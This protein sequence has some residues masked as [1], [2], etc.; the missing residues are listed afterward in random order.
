[1][2]QKRFSAISLWLLLCLVSLPAFA[3]TRYVKP[4][5]SGLGDGSSWANASGDLQAMINASNS[6]D[7]IWVSAG[8]YIPNRRADAINVITVNDRRNAFVLK[9]G[10]K[11]YGGFT[12]VITETLLSQRNYTANVTILSGDI[13]GT[14]CYHVV[15]AAGAASNGLLD[16]FTVSNGY[17]DINSGNITVNGSVIV[18][19][20]GAGIYIT[21]SSP[22]IQNCIITSNSAFNGISVGGAG[23]LCG[24]TASPV[25]TNCTISNNNTVNGTGSNM[26]GAGMY[27]ASATATVSNC[28]FNNNIAAGE[29][30]GLY[31][32]TTVTSGITN[33]NFTGNSSAV[34]GGGLCNYSTIAINITGCDFTSNSSPYGAGL[35]N[36]TASPVISNCNFLSNTASSGGG[37]MRNYATASPTVN[38][39]VFSGNTG[40]TY[41]GGM[42]NSSTSAP[43]VTNCLFS[44]NTATNGGG[45]ANDITSNAVIVNSTIAANKAI[46]AGGGVYNSFSIPDLKN[47]I[48]YGNTAASGYS[49]NGTSS[50]ITYSNIEGGYFGTGNI[51]INPAFSSPQLASSAP[52]TLGDYHLQDCSPAFNLG[53]NA[54]VPSNITT[55][56]Q[57]N[58]RIAYSTVDMGPYEVQSSFIFTLIPTAGILYVDKTKAG[59]GSSWANAVTE[60]A[61]A[62]KAAKYNSTITQIWVAKGTYNPLYDAA[63]LG[64]SP[65]NNRDQSFVLVNNVKVYGSFSGGETTLNGRDF[66]TNETILSGDIGIANDNADNAYHVLI[67]AGDIGNAVLDGFSVVKGE[68]G[69]NSQITVNSLLITRNA[70]GG[71]INYSSS[72]SITNCTISGNSSYSAGGMYNYNSS[73]S[74]VNCTISGNSAASAGGGMLNSFS[75]LALTNCTVSSNSSVSHGGGIYNLSLSTSITNCTISGNNS[76]NGNGGGMYN[77]SS[78]PVITNCA[79][80]GNKSLS[81]GGG[82]L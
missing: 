77:F 4:V 67:S 13:T 17:A 12:G 49:L 3:V 52:T 2:M 81:D 16:G 56:L 30:G 62:L 10:V 33:C 7:E 40:G 78:S 75:S 58:P 8:T 35:Y 19:S 70:G 18:A 39:C 44:G 20:R 26:S 48:V 74:I 63:T 38:N 53:N 31:V 59:D 27:L 55:D 45:I 47:C 28:N 24:S 76:S 61:D 42:Y 64:C 65:T 9:T 60:L 54:S 32:G 22:S 34:N 68:G 73:S 50:T 23:I 66:I 25:I 36:Q 51:D 15:I 6:L 80:T 71:I 29:G 1:M 82:N 11:I 5:S 41:G 79:I 46:T 14:N 43:A 37:G 72:P 21:V 69:A 57:G